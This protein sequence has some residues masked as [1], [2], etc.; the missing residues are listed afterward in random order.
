LYQKQI[1]H[2]LSLAFSLL[3]ENPRQ[4]AIAANPGTRERQAFL[5]PGL[6]AEVYVMFDFHDNSAGIQKGDQH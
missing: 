5:A 1:K 3:T 2:A 4:N 6:H